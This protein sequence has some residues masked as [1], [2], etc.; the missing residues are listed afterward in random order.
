M[1]AYF[2]QF[3]GVEIFFLICAIVGGAFVGMRFVM[4]LVGMHDGGEGGDAA[5]GGHDV[6][7]HHADSDVGFK[8]LSLQGITSFLMMF[9][10]VGM[11][12]YHESRMG[13]LVSMAGGLAAGLASVWVIAKMFALV[14]RLQSS[15]TIPIE[16]AV[17]AQGNV[18]LT[19]PENGTGRV[20]ISVRNSLRE[21]DASSQDHQR[22]ETGRAVRVVWV[23]GNILVVEAI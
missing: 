23:D 8:L 16:S 5:V 10:L 21:Y 7:G 11:A 4:L 14:V 9:G 13:M 12:F 19:I 17:G 1:A 18:Y 2:S 3:N 20:L 15:G 22:I 6:D